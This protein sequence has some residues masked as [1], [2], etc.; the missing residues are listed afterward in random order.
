MSLAVFHHELSDCYVSVTGE[1]RQHRED[2]IVSDHMKYSQGSRFYEL[3]EL[4]IHQQD[5][6]IQSK[7]ERYAVKTMMTQLIKPMTE[8]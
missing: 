1:L 2:V 7:M 8:E 5:E 4:L 3:N 6:N